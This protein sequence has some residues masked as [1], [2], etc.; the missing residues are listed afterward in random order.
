MGDERERRSPADTFLVKVYEFRGFSRVRAG[1]PFFPFDDWQEK[2]LLIIGVARRGKSSNAVTVPQDLV[3]EGGYHEGFTKQEVFEFP[4]DGR[5]DIFEVQAGRFPQR[6]KEFL[7][8]L[9]ERF[10][11]GRL[12]SR[13]R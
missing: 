10:N 1:R 7:E 8:R 9:L 6:R 2:R 4:G 13:R 5:K 11:I 3:R 12:I